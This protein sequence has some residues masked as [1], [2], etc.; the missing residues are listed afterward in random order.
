MTLLLKQLGTAMPVRGLIGLVAGLL[1]SIAGPTPMAGLYGAG[2]AAPSTPIPVENALLKTMESTTVAAQV[3]G[4]LSALPIKEGSLITVGQEIGKVRDTAVRLQVERA[5]TAL[6]IA[7][8]KQTND[9]DER[10]A[11]KSEAVSLNEY[12]RAVEAN[13]RVKDTYPLNEIDRLKLVADR[14]KLEVERAVY[15]QN[16]AALDVNLAEIEYSQAQELLDRH[17]ILAP[18]PGIVVSL[19]KRLGEWVEPGSPLLKL[20][21]TDRLRIEGFINAQVAIP[22]LMGR[23]ATV[24]VEREQA[25]QSLKGQVTF[26]SPDANPVNSQVRIFLEVDNQT[27]DLRPGLRVQASIDP[28]P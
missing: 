3:S 1:L 27:G 20:V 2:N 9:I 11:E 15:N 24:M 12:L 19:E 5:K 28:A 23:S 7:K 17:R 8:K 18:T 16:M 4:I 10:L 21:R 22:E 26:I 13:K 25:R 14:A 6:D